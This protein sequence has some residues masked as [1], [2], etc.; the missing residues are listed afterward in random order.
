MRLFRGLL[1]AAVVALSFGAGDGAS[2]ATCGTSPLTGNNN[3]LFTVSGVAAGC[4]GSDSSPFAITPTLTVGLQNYQHIDSTG[5]NS[6]GLA[7]G[8]LTTSSTTS[9]HSSLASWSVGTLTGFQ[10]LL[11]V[12]Q[13]AGT[14][15]FNPDYGMF[16]M[17]GTFTGTWL[18]EAISPQRG[19]IPLALREISLY[20][21]LAQVSQTPLPPAFLLFGTVLAGWS[22]W[23]RWM[24]RDAV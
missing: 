22:G 9:I 23:R 5:T 6:A 11:L 13:H 24:R 1:T 7:N 15:N 16:A 3:S 21:Q 2:A 19:R 8:I 12:F 18:I 20:G 10:N 14:D 4:V 17:N